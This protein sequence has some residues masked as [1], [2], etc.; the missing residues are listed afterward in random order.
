MIRRALRYAAQGRPVLA[1]IGKVPPAETDGVYAASTDPVAIREMF[2][3]PGLNIGISLRDYLVVDVDFKHDGPKWLAE[4]RERLLGLTLTCKTG[5]GGWHFW[6][7]RPDG[8]LRGLIC[9]GVDLRRGA[10]HYVVVPPSIHP[11]TGAQYEWVNGFPTEP[12][13]VP[14]WLLEQVRRPEPERAEPTEHRSIDR[15]TLFERAQKYV[16]LCDVSISGSEG[17]LTAIRTAA[18]LIAK[19]PELCDEDYW[20]LLLDWNRG[21]QP[22]WSSKEL[23]HKLSDALKRAGRRDRAA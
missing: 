5:G 6:F 10:G 9:K 15:S 22:P 3:R 23:R 18:K 14:P 19:F 21:C 4:H 20:D 11:I 16:A 2:N 1:L 8:D 7:H 12:Q 13:L 17:H